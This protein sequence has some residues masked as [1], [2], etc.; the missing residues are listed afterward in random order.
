MPNVEI[1]L[2]GVGVGVWDSIV[3]RRVVDTLSKPNLAYIQ[4]HEANDATHHNH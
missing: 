3:G 2:I 1:P 4:Y